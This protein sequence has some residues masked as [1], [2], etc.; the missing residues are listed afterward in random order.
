MQMKKVMPLLLILML[1]LPV[2]VFAV[3][4]EIDEATIDARLMEDGTVAVEEQFTYEFDG[5]FEG[6][7]RE[8]KPKTGTEIT[9]F[10]AHE[11]NK[12][13]KVEKEKSLYK[14]YRSGDDET[15]TVS[16]NYVIEGAIEKFDDG[17]EFYWP[18]FDDRNESDY[19]QMTIAVH[20]PAPTEEVLFL[21]YDEAF[22]KGIASDEGSVVFKLGKVPEGSNGDIRVIYDAQLFP[23]AASSDGTVKE[24]LLADREQQE[25]EAAAFTANQN[26]ASTIGK[27]A[28]PALG[29]ILAGI[30]FSAYWRARK[31]KA[32]IEVRKDGFSVPDE[33]LS[34]P[35]AVYF[36]HS[37]YLT[38][39]AMAAALLE[40]VRKEIVKQLSKD[41]FELT[42]K[43][44]SLPHEQTL[45]DLL[46]H[47]I[48][49]GQTF[50][51]SEVEAYSKKELNHSAYNDAVAK[52]NREV[53]DEVKGRHFKEKVPALR[54]M[55]AS[56]AAASAGLAIYTGIYELY[57]LM[58]L[59]LLVALIAAS[60]ALFYSPITAE[61]HTVK[62][63]WKDMRA[64]MQNLPASEWQ[65][66][67]ADDR[68]RA[69]A[70]LLAV[71]GKQLDKKSRSFS[72][73]GQYAEETD[74]ALYFNPILL[75]GVFVAASSNTSVSASSGSSSVSSGG[76][77]GGGGGGSGAF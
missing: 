15:I 10:T 22:E 9:G 36:T 31:K 47:K 8:L 35:A 17:A 64:A 51:L 24:Q 59:S 26:T 20:P 66:L 50:Q 19:E 45:I 30:L 56:I 46:F 38:P 58:A 48:G 37:P 52:W 23:G 13:L 44:A 40:L 71:D 63:Q 62:A 75:S 74:S 42:G 4:F 73:A 57:P 6:I 39:D 33:K 3:D 69:Y 70:Y 12:K 43:K 25:A 7:T 53:A 77:V 55:V 28:L 11:N 34:L 29:L 41:Q 18:F 2:T 67:D 65:A 68:L 27:I 49:D 61:G 16:L 5:D 14:I 72:A 54:G 21:G 76:G 60:F 1:L 32:A